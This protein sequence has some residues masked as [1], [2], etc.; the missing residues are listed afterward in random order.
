MQLS[1]K[2]DEAQVRALRDA[3]RNPTE[4]GMQI[5][6]SWILATGALLVLAFVANWGWNRYRRL[7]QD[8]APLRAFEAMAGDL[9]LGWPDRRFLISVA[10]Q[11]RLPSPLTLMLSGDT[12]A[13]HAAAYAG[14][15]PSISRGL[16]LSRAEAIRLRLF[17]QPATPTSQSNVSQAIAPAASV[18][19]QENAAVTDPS[20]DPHPPAEP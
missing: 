12:L 16:I 11:Q 14:A 3:I 18:P 5:P 1:T 6:T 13:Y 10:Q 4:Q 19:M 15:Q 7:A 9:G 2:I 8:R 17:G 20:H